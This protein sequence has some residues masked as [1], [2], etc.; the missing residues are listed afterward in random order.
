[1]DD[2]KH[3][4]LKLKYEGLEAANRFDANYS[5]LKEFQL[6]LYYNKNSQVVA[7]LTQLDC[8]K[9]LLVSHYQRGHEKDSEFI[10]D[11]PEPIIK[12][13]ADEYDRITT[14]AAMSQFLKDSLEPLKKFYEITCVGLSATLTSKVDNSS[15][16]I[17]VLISPENA[18]ESV[19]IRPYYG[20]D[21]EMKVPLSARDCDK[22]IMA[23]VI[24]ISLD[25]VVLD[26]ITAQKKKSGVLSKMWDMVEQLA[27]NN[28][29]NGY[30]DR[31]KFLAEL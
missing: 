27:S 18:K 9:Q 15:D 8:K 21:V 28:V 20:N 25:L 16:R 30:K 14:K 4:L 5:W 12:Y 26:I 22:E 7:R 1:M 3:H 31:E 29:K 11:N 10:G 19:I 13:V 6:R 17:S 23:G 24:K 2:P